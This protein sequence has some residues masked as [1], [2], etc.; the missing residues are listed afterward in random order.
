M[1]LY[2]DL[3]GDLLDLLSIGSGDGDREGVD[4]STMQEYLF[5]ISCLEVSPFNLIGSD[6]LALLELE[7]I[8]LSINDLEP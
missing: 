5:N 3:G 4:R 8:F 7:D 6:V 1:P 2:S